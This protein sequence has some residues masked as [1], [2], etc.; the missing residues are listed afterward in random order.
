MKKKEFITNILRKADFEVTEY[1]R[2]EGHPRVTVHPKGHPDSSIDVVVFADSP[3]N[4]ANTYRNC[5]SIRFKFNYP[6]LFTDA[7]EAVRIR[8]AF[9]CY[10]REREFNAFA[11]TYCSPVH[12]YTLYN[13]TKAN[14]VVQVVSQDCF[15]WRECAKN[16]TKAEVIE[17]ALG[18]QTRYKDGGNVFDNSEE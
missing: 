13:Q 16:M 15:P 3:Y 18:P 11:R 4:F 1:G 17:D 7:S 5:Y 10:L 6:R 14:Y 2:Y 8:R 9:N 12:R